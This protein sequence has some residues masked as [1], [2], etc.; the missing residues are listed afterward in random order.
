MFRLL[1]LMLFVLPP[2]LIAAKAQ[3]P[4]AVEPGSVE[5][6]ASATGDSRFLSPWVSSLPLSLI[7]PSPT[8]FFGRIAGA[9]DS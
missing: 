4:D 9:R 3:A 2:W 6:I 5:A 8:A 7:V 1:A